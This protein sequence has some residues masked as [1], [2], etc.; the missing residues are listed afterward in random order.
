MADKV[1]LKMHCYFFLVLLM[2]NKL[3]CSTVGEKKE[4]SCC[5][6]DLC[7]KNFTSSTEKDVS[8]LFNL[9][10]IFTTLSQKL[11]F[12]YTYAD[13]SIS[14]NFVPIFMTAFKIGTD[15]IIYYLSCLQNDR[16]SFYQLHL[17]NFF[18]FY[19]F[20]GGKNYSMPKGLQ[21]LL[22]CATCFT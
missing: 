22:S 2:V 9:Y 4:E 11:K 19:H 14:P 12:G 8:R 10:Q 17:N 6:Y 5:C 16:K 3:Y 7:D 20:T 21:I 1:F 18:L 15:M 13:L